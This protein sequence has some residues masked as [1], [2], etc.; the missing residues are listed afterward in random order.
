MLHKN[1]TAWQTGDRTEFYFGETSHVCQ[2]SHTYQ[3][4]VGIDNSFVCRQELF[5]YI[6]DNTSFGYQ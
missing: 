4:M 2:K 1:S 3:M 6:F 5:Q